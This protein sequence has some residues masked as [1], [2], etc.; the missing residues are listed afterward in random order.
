MASDLTGLY[1]GMTSA[2]SLATNLGVSPQ[3]VR[4]SARRLGVGSFHVVRVTSFEPRFALTAHEV[5][6]VVAELRNRAV[7]RRQEGVAV[8]D[9]CDNV[10]R[11]LADR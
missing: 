5:E 7:E 8:V 6:A 10:L 3:L 2:T 1:S 9:A 11:L 4:N